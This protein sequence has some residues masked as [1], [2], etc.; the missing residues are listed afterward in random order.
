MSLGQDLMYAV[1]N[2]I[3]RT[4]KSIFFPYRTKLLTNSTD[5][6]NISNCLGHGFSYS[7]LEKMETENACQ[8]L[9]EMKKDNIV[10]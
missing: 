9:T 5:S 7:M 2:G 3:V 8:T 6:I 4:V 1:S 10:P